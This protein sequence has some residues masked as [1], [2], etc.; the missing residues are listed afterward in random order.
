MLPT[1]RRIKE[2]LN[3]DSVSGVFVWIKKSTKNSRSVVGNVSGSIHKHGYRV[4]SIDG[5]QYQA[6]RLAWVYVY[7]DGLSLFIDHI[8]G[9]RS[10]NRISNLRVATQ[11][12][13]NQNTKKPRSD[14]STGFLGVSTSRGKFMA[15]IWINGHNKFL[16]YF[17]K[18]EEAH[19]AYITAKRINHEFCTI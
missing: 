10:D 18:A 3:Y 13:N 9:I 4:I 16:G 7:G 19:D 15:Q 8:N 6:S 2:L 5:N 14:N 17:D 11:Q 12:Q 1:Q